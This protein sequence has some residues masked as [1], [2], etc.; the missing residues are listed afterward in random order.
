MKNI[1]VV[2]LFFFTL[3]LSYHSHAQDILKS[4]D[5]STVK[6][7]NLSDADIA[8]IKAQLQSNHMTIEQAE[9]MALSKGMSA[10]EFAKLKE[11]LNSLSTGSLNNKAAGNTTGKTNNSGRV[12]D[13]IANNKV[14]DSVNAMI[15]GSELFDNPTLNFEPDSNLATPVNYILGPGD[16]LQVS[17]YGVQ[18]YNASIPVSVEGKISIQYVG[19]IAVSGMS[20]EAATQKIK[21]AIARVYSTV[22]SGQSQVSVSLSRIRTISITIVGGKQPGN[23]SISSLATVYNALHLAGGPGKN[24]SYRN[25]ELIRN[26]K[27]YKYVDIYR[28]LVKGD[29][30]DNVT[31][32]ENDVI[33]IPV[34]TQRVTVTGEVKRPGIFE[35]KKGETFSDLL[36]FASGFNEFAYTASVNVTQKTGK[37]F[38][39]KD[40][41]EKEF[42]SYQPQAGDVFR[43]T[44][45][46]NRFENRIKIE[47]A[48]FRPDYYSYSEGMRVSDLIQRA[49]GLK[50]DAYT[51]RARIIRLQSDLTTEIVTV[52][53]AA[54]L[55]GDRTA[56]I[57]L[58]REDEVTIYSVLDFKEDYKVTIDGEV[59]NP[60][61]YDYV[62]NLSLNDLI[63]QV[64]GLTG[65]A[66]KRVEIA[67]M[68]KSDERDDNDPKR[69]E[70]I[71]LEITADNN[72]QAKNF[73]LQPFD[74]INIRRMAV[75]E[76]PQ[77]VKVSGAVVYPGK[78][79]LANKK[80]S[81]YNVVMRAGGLTSVANI[82][83]MKILR[84]IK[85]EQID[86]IESIDLNLS[87]ND[88]L[89][90]KLTKKLKEEAKFAVIP[91]DWE[92]IEKNKEHYSN[93]TLFPEDE[94][95]V[96][97]FNEGVKVSG[98]VLLNSEIPYRK[99]KGLNYYLNAV[100]GVNSKGWKKK[101]YVI[102]P[103]GKADVTSSFLFFKSYPKVTPDSQIVVPEKPERKRMSTGEWVS[104][105]SVFSSLALLI[106]TAF[107]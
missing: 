64:G 33:R 75:Y 44:K 60:G 12:L 20:I 32:K 16:E 41:S 90:E 94:I 5:L 13:K 88:T 24:G 61:E 42:S 49:E 4:S 43:I 54:V 46:L 36:R 58:K 81:V 45:I 11:R 25:I 101:A 80:E 47:G 37:E 7:A 96:S 67:R 28:F 72:E 6:V 57:A 73:V 14:K 92:K 59:K 31:L 19:E 76:K 79:V 85:Q 40:I 91:L 10:A 84:P 106:I 9:P 95:V 50:E 8:K 17:V 69:V 56:D 35:M 2:F 87:K 103:N 18:E 38:K 53:L 93:V 77:M 34:Y 78:Y 102:Y 22:A 97:T 68:I 74:V 100:G 55:A 99:S 83:G 62:D 89:K 1:T 63:V 21:A 3:L 29:Q 52:D 98:N 65:S 104:I 86:D 27:V 48:V 71:A 23:Y 82:E 66:S 26:N 15:F 70:L 105:G 107:K 51:K 39:V 30:S